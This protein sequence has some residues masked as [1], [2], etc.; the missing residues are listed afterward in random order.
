MGPCGEV[1]GVTESVMGS[2]MRLY[3]KLADGRGWIFDD[4]LLM[5]H[6]C[7]VVMIAPPPMHSAF[8]AP[9]MVP[10]PVVVGSEMLATEPHAGA[11]ELA[12]RRHHWARGCRGGVKRNKRRHALLAA[13]NSASNSKGKA[14]LPEARQP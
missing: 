7:S 1:F 14:C 6:D 12:P 5:P 13:A 2:D 10:C 8:A 9:Q 3:L 11:A 4:S